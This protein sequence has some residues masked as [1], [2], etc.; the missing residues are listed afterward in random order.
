MGRKALPYILNV[1]LGSIAG[2]RGLQFFLKNINTLRERLAPN[3]SQQRGELIT[4]V[5]YLLR[6]TL[7]AAIA[8]MLNFLHCRKPQPGQFYTGFAAANIG[9]NT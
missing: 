6:V 8:T 1:S 5:F 7:I 2:I 4:L 3:P 9:N